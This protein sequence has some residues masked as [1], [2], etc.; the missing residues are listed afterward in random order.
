[1]NETLLTLQQVMVLRHTDPTGLFGLWGQ[2]PVRALDGVSL[3]IQKGETLGVIGGSGGGKTT[4]AEVVTLRRPIDRGQILVNGQDVT[5]LRGDAKRRLQRR[6]RL[7]PQN[8][9]DALQIEQTVAKQLTDLLKRNEIPDPEGRIRKALAQV[10]LGEEFLQRTPQEMS[11]GQQQRLAIA[12]VLMLNPLLIAADEPLSGVDPRL[13][14]ELGNLLKRLQ[15]EQG[16]GM[17]LISQDLR[18]L[19]RLADRIAVLHAG[20]LYEVADK[21]AILGAPRHPYS[22]RFLGQEPGAMPAEEDMAGKV[23]LGCPWQAHCPSATDLCRKQVPALMEVAP[24][25]RVA[26]HHLDRG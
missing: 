21:E 13:Q 26:C 9:T 2:K 23:Y 16:F 24:G 7:I 25:H 8:P 12:R 19:S 10:E 6:L 1:M 22:R 11:G 17:L 4:L 3:T 14:V 15:R 18:V 20:R 5:K